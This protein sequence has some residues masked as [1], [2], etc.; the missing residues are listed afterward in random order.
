MLSI[1]ITSYR[2][3]GTI[4]QAIDAF[5][6]QIPADAEILVICPDPET[7]AVVNDYARRYPAVR[8][9]ADPQ[10]GKP[11]ALN[12][13]FKAARGDL[14]I[15]SD[16]D[17]LIT[18]K[19]VP[20]LI[21]PFD[22]PQVGAVTGRPIS[23][24]PRST[25]LGYWSH[26]LTDSVHEVRLK[27]DREKQ[28]LLCSGY[29]FAVRKTL[30]Q[31]I[32]EDALAEDAVISQMI[33]AQGYR[34]RYTP[35]AQVSVKYPTTYSD[36]LR[37]KIRSAGGYMQKYVRESSNRMRSPLLEITQGARLALAYGRTPREFLWT[38]L[39]FAARAH[40]WLLVIINVRVRRLPLSA[41]WKR[42]E[43]TK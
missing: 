31:P 18:E 25:M 41:L 36:W 42:V 37:Q 1:L 32:P 30:I 5:L 38:L 7:I 43:T 35:D 21:A 20:V 19:S 22:D 14:V 24:S 3:P 29:L 34:I 4:G 10:H 40:L 13:G 16:G 39:L 12:I 9:I 26:L 17:V 8:H 11:T 27:R 6:S 23:A 33:A 2:E 28:Y 15:L